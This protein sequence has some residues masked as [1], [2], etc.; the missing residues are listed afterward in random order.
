LI[1]AY[2]PSSSISAIFRITTS[3][4]IFKNYKGSPV[5]SILL[6]GALKDEWF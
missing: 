2:H 4:T 3:S 5:P 6:E 1:I